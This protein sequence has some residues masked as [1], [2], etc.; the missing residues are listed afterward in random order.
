MNYPSHWRLAYLLA[1]F[2]HLGAW[3]FV[4]LALPH[5]TLSLPEPEPVQ[6]IEW[7][8]DLPP[9]A[10]EPDLPP[11][12]AISDGL[13]QVADA[14]VEETAEDLV[15]VDEGE[16]PPLDEE[17]PLVAEDDAAAIAQL[18]KAE[19]EGKDDGK[20]HSVIIR[21]GGGGGQQMGENAKLIKPFYPAP[22][23][24]SFGGR[25][26]VSA[27]IGKDGRIKE[28]KIKITSGRPSVD[29]VAMSCARKWVYK[30][31]TDRYGKP[32][33]CDAIISIPFTRHTGE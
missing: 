27:R 22:G 30:P 2:F 26:S 8:A 20:A 18:K 9:G 10:G 23:V 13:P 3:L 16:P 7:L 31:A 6:E 32:M 14:T 19:Q 4:S 5:L 24:V 12:E 33:E 11:G 1:F 21:S 15:P 29:A 28:T 25:V 17:T